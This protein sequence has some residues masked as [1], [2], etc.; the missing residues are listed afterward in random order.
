M[1][2]WNLETMGLKNAEARPGLRAS[3]GFSG[4]LSWQARPGQG[5]AGLAI[6]ASP[7]GR[8][9]TGL[10]QARPIRGTKSYREYIRSYDDGTIKKFSF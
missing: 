10:R 7:A 4:F 2:T 3:T 8:A 9:C 5:L 1:K 6:L